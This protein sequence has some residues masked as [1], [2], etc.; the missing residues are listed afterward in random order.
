TST[1]I[2]RRRNHA[3]LLEDFSQA[4]EI[5]QRQ[6]I[7][8]KNT[9]GTVHV[10]GSDR[11]HHAGLIQEFARIQI[12]IRKPRLD[13]VGILFGETREQIGVITAS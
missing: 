6:N 5:M 7:R 9:N 13:Y 4:G 2:E 3:F 11:D 1:I 12:L 10:A 8:V